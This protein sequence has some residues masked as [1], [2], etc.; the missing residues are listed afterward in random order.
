MQQTLVDN[1]I[2]STL[3]EVATD[4][5]GA[6]YIQPSTASQLSATNVIS[7]LVRRLNEM[8]RDESREV[9]EIML[10][11]DSS[12]SAQSR[13]DSALGLDRYRFLVRNVEMT[14]ASFSGDRR[15]SV[16]AILSSQSSQNAEAEIDITTGIDGYIFN[17]RECTVVSNTG[18]VDIPTQQTTLRE[19]VEREYALTPAFVGMFVLRLN[20]M[21]GMKKS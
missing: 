20:D 4:W 1:A 17:L 12:V 19:A 10:S 5:A 21:L 6:T 9:V 18:R 14:S 15:I 11:S 16:S 3:R 8:P 2:Q 7:N 13:L